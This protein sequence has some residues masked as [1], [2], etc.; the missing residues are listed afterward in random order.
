MDDERYE[1]VFNLDLRAEKIFELRPLQVALSI[2]VFNVLN[3]DT[4]LQRVSRVNIGTYNNISE[5]ISP[6]VVRAG[7]R[8]SF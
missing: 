4:V 8:I 1:D 7:A 5:T 6:R 2:D 3:E